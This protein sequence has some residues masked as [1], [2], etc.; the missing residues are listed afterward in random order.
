MTLTRVDV[1]RAISR[2]SWALRQKNNLL[3]ARPIETGG[4]G[5]PHGAPVGFHVHIWDQDRGNR[6]TLGI[7]R[8]PDYVV[9]VDAEGW[10]CAQLGLSGQWGVERDG[11]NGYPIVEVETPAGFIAGEIQWRKEQ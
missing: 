5:P 10:D 8:E 11:H 3:I 1:Q 7:E 9:A 4:F 2:L 6:S